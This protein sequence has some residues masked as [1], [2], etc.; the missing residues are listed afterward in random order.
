MALIEALLSPAL[1]IANRQLRQS[2]EALAIAES[3]AGRSF[4]VRLNQ[5]ALAL[6]L[7][8][9]PDGLRL[10]ESG[11]A[12]PDLIIE[13]S[14]PGLA[15]L[16]G[17]DAEAAIRDGDVTLTGATDIAEELQALLALARPDFGQELGRVIGDDAAGGLEDLVRSAGETGRTRLRELGETLGRR[18]AAAEDLPNKDDVDAFAADVRELRDRVARLEAR[19]NA[20]KDR[21][22]R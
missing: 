2:S 10:A 3:L 7:V 6:A 13:G 17:G 9:D 14:L 11:A 15:R 16:I 4:A 19:I 1:G 8:I 12:D 18:V 22:G 20:V 5:S 21:R